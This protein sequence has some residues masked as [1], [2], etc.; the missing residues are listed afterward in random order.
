MQKKIIN[1]IQSCAI[2][3]MQNLISVIKNFSSPYSLYDCFMLAVFVSVLTSTFVIERNI[4]FK[5]H[6]KTID[7]F[8]DVSCAPLIFNHIYFICQRMASSIH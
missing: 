8:C 1:E 4:H 2:K 5:S 3:I 7:K 6:S